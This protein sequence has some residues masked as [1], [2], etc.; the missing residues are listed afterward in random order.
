MPP[1]SW[2]LIVG[3]QVSSAGNDP[4]TAQLD[5]SSPPTLNNIGLLPLQ[6]TA[7]AYDFFL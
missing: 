5:W 6:E 3:L 4:D 1:K 2:N 7:G